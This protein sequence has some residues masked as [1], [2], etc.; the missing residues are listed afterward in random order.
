MSGRSPDQLALQVGQQV[1]VVVPSLAG[2]VGTLE[3]VEQAGRERV[4]WV[5]FPTTRPIGPPTRLLGFRDYEL[6]PAS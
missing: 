3:R 1:V 6:E 2:E 5:R 4:Y